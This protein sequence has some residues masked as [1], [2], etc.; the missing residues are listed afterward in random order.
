MRHARVSARRRPPSVKC[1]GDVE[2]HQLI[3]FALVADQ[4]RNAKAAPPRGTRGL[5]GEYQRATAPTRAAAQG[6]VD[7]I[8]AT[9]GYRAMHARPGTTVCRAH[10][11]PA[12]CGDRNHGGQDRE[13]EQKRN[14]ASPSLASAA[15]S[16]LI[17]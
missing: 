2:V 7:L 1:G 17:A 11:L 16:R 10:A 15:P 9:D 8:E 6:G 3:A 12:P 14:H 13:A 5:A 4:A